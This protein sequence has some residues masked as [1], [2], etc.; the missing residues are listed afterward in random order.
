MTFSSLNVIK[1]SSPPLRSAG[2]TG[3]S[4]GVGQD[5]TASLH[6][7]KCWFL[8][9]I[10]KTLTSH[11]EWRAG[12][13]KRGRERVGEILPECSGR[14]GRRLEGSCQG[15]SRQECLA[16]ELPPASHWQEDVERSHVLTKGPV[17]F[18]LPLCLPLYRSLSQ[19]LSLS[20]TLFLPPSLSLES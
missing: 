4:C 20:H 1:L 2:E 6:T 11:A 8:L 5:P 18:C 15:V 14:R 10:I 16:T 13:K 7:R 3:R 12:E 19:S 17:G 9:F